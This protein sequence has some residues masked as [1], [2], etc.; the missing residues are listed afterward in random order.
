MHSFIYHPIG[1][2]LFFS[3][4]F[5]LSSTKRFCVVYDCGADKNCKKNLRGAVEEFE[6]KNKHIDMLVIS[7]FD[8]D[9]ISGIQYLLSKC[10]ISKIVLPYLTDT[11]KLMVISEQSN[12]IPEAGLNWYLSFTNDPIS[13]LQR[14]EFVVN[15]IIFVYSKHSKDIVDIKERVVYDNIS[16]YITSILP[17]IKAISDESYYV[18]DC[19]L[20]FKFFNYP[21][22]PQKRS[23]FLKK[24]VDEM[25]IHNDSSINQMA[26]RILS[27]LQSIINFKVSYNSINSADHN[28]VSLLMMYSYD[29]PSKPVKAVLYPENFQLSIFE[30]DILH[31]K[32]DEA[33]IKH[34]LT[35][36]ISLDY[37]KKHK[38]VYEHYKEL[39]PSTDFIQV[40]HHGSRHSWNRDLLSEVSP[41]TIFVFSYG[42]N[43]SYKH[44]HSEVI[45]SIKGPFRHFAANQN[46]KLIYSIK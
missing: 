10:S 25:K 7:H 2:G 28:N 34:L 13:A 38:K 44:P 23:A 37:K 6:L 24:V 4:E 18:I 11:E 46:T 36:D 21:V 26:Y 45:D 41:D 33:S 40:P 35:G 27:N 22:T 1:Q 31:M 14:Y 16:N 3:A 32:K 8:Y 30:E 15:E 29:L 39:L 42:M 19:G 12:E 17:E 9:H 43:N 20:R 5:I